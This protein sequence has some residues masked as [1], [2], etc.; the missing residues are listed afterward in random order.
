[1]RTRH[2]GDV[3]RPKGLRG[4]SCK[5]SDWMI[6]RKIP[7]ALRDQIPLICVNDEIAAFYIQEEW[8]VAY[9]F[10]EYREPDHQRIWLSYVRNSST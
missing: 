7:R 1:M 4:R 10:I 8:I 9:P 3:F 6:D 5:L 2:P